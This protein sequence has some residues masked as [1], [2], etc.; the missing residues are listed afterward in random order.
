MHKHFQMMPQTPY[1]DLLAIL[2]SM[3]KAESLRWTTSSLYQI[4]SRSRHIPLDYLFRYLLVADDEAPP[5]VEANA[6][7][8][9]IYDLVPL[10]R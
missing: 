5:R 9:E 1:Y 6:S 8:S 3:G 7:V 4:R 2:L 10:G